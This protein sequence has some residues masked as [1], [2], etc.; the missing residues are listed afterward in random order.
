MRAILLV[1]MLSSTY[2]QPA[3]AQEKPKSA[4]SEKD[5]GLDEI[6]VTAQRREESLQ[7]VPV[8]VTAFGAD[9]LESA[10]MTNVRNLSGYAPNFQVTTQG[11]QSTPNIN[12]RGISSGTANNAV[13]PKV[14]IYLDGVYVGRTVG[15]VFDLADIER[16][17]V[18]RGPQGTLFG[19]NATAGAV[20]LVTSP[21]TGEFGVKQNLSYGNDNAFRSRTILNLPAF[22]PFSL[23]LA[24][25]H[26]EVD[27]DTDNLIAGRTID[28]SQR[29]AAFGTLRYADKLGGRNTDAVQVAARFDEGNGLT[30]D[31]RFDY[32]DSRSVGRAAQLLGALPGAVGT[33]HKGILAYQPLTGG[34]TNLSVKRLDAVANA[35]SVER[36]E[37][38]GHS[39]TVTWAQS[40]A[41][42]VKSITAFRKLHQHPYIYDMAASGGVRFTAAQLGM[43][44]SGNVAGIP[45]A[46]VGP[47]DIL[48]SL[49][50]AR[51][52]QQR[53]LSQEVQ[54]QITQ[55]AFDLVAGAFYF[56]ER[57]PETGIAGIFQPV[58][59][60]VVIPGPLDARFGSGT[61]RST[62]I[63]DSMAAYGQL[64]YHLTDTID[65]TSG[66]R[67]TID[68]RQTNL[69]AVSGLQGGSLQPGTYKSS[70]KK[71][72]YTL[73]GTWR[74]DHNITAYGKI[75]TGY[76]SGG[77]MNAIPYG[78]ESLTAYEGGLKTQF[79]GNR[80]RAN[81]AAFYMDYKDLQTSNFV[82][83][84]VSFA[85]AGKANITGFEAEVDAMPIDGLT[86]SGSAG[87]SDFNYKKFVL[88]GVD[89][90][91]V[92]RP[93]YF[94]KWTTRASA[95]YDMPEFS[96]GGHFFARV[97]ARWRSNSKIVSTP[98]ADPV[99]EDRA[100]TKAYWL[101]DGRA[102]I[103]NFPVGGVPVGLSIYGQNLFDKNYYSFGAPVTGLSGIYDRGR[104]YGVE[105]SMAF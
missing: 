50:T 69:Y 52:S 91:N 75:S 58:T 63:N 90:A 6:V 88:N 45:G 59:N 101:V 9:A 53:Q 15:A 51:E 4:L 67:Y 11:L 65:L 29:S 99:M 98:I 54:F 32:T 82:N 22:G 96:G 34:I 43:L 42:T 78:P 2:L 86:L 87:Y 25:L 72:N 19:R 7:D 62:T 13:D 17:E 83:G 94:S 95:Q 76:V 64:T 37:V 24:Y 36:V 27:G 16:V 103:A 57:A 5:A 104:T 105:L 97:D 61:T 68:D 10:R 93:A 49:L 18:L 80:L 44:L 102:G 77:I 84:V 12:I 47:N 56:H 31:Y 3:Y 23:K 20:S 28:L 100:T 71:L 85:N 8:A 26:D 74:P 92:A 21:P 66:L 35:S 30:V 70:Y 40:D 1:A 33:I 79:F 46:P 60:G 89:V 55:D 38:Q 14:G 81:F 73:I 39:L 41:V 48:F